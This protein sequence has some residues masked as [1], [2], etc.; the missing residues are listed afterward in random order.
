MRGIDIGTRITKYIKT[1][2]SFKL[3]A[4]IG[5][6]MMLFAPVNTV[7]SQATPGKLLSALTSSNG[8]EAGKALLGLF[9]QYKADGK[10]DFTN[11]ANLS[12]LLK[13]VDSCKGLKGATSETNT[14]NFLSGLISGSK[15]LVN[16]NNGS[17]VLSA[18]TSLANTDMSSLDKSVAAS[19]VSGLLKKSSSSGSGNSAATNAAGSILTSLFKGLK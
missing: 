9:T 14:T 15:N 13:L 7:E 19:A 4:A 18:L 10:L 17:S 5:A 6:A 8:I 3:I 1:M 16:Q 2:K 11:T 12:N